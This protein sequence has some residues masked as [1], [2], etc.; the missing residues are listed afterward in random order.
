VTEPTGIR[1]TADDDDEPGPLRWLLARL[2]RLVDG[3]TD[4]LAT[5]NDVPAWQ[6][7][8]QTLLTRYHTAAML[9][10]YRGDDE[11]AALARAKANAR[12]QFTFLARF[13]RVIEDTGYL[14]GYRARAKLYAQSIGASY[15]NGATQLLPLPAMPKDGTTQC[16]TNCQCR[17]RL[18]WL[19]RTR[20]D[21]DAYW[22]RGPRDSCQT[23]IVRER[24]WAPYRIRGG[25]AQGGNR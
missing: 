9:T 10:A 12:R 13:A 4:V 2:T 18:D 15:W 11:A 16:K 6:E 19:D 25:V 21:V 14:P 7:A 1:T 3:T 24:R 22:E 17:W 5:T 20:G 8:M 23:C